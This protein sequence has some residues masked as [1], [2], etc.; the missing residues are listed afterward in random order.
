MRPCPPG[1]KTTR[2]S[3]NTALLGDLPWADFPECPTDRAFPGPAPEK[4]APF[5]AAFLVK[6]HEDKRYMNDLRTFLVEHPAL[7]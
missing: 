1:S 5:A 6:L 3:P 2:W 4:R 7:V